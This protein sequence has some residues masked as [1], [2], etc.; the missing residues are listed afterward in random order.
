MQYVDHRL[1]VAAAILCCL[2]SAMDS[3]ADDSNPVESAREALN[4]Q[5][6]Q[7]ISRDVKLSR[8]TLFGDGESADDW[9]QVRYF[10]DGQRLDVEVKQFEKDKIVPVFRAR[11]IWTDEGWVTRETNAP[12]GTNGQRVAVSKAP[13]ARNQVLLRPWALPIFEGIL[14]GDQK[15]AI[16]IVLDANPTVDTDMIGGIKC[17]ELTANT[18]AGQYIVWLDAAAGMLPRKIKQ[19][20]EGKTL[21]EHLRSI[22]Q[23]VVMDVEISDIKIEC[24][25]GQYVITGATESGRI[26]SKDKVISDW[27]YVAESQ[28]TEVNPRFDA[29]AF[30]MDG[31]PEGAGLLNEDDPDTRYMWK[32]GKAIKVYE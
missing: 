2:A 12:S 14:S 29:K 10:R 25:D 18:Q 21:P 1:W 19:H 4:A 30:V 23:P 32:A 3:F 31:I 16:S 8:K 13:D 5:S 28:K 11:A 26:T 7:K 17:V 24:L 6:R 27:R 22:P 20:N 15:S 9:W